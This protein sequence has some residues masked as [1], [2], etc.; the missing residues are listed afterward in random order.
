MRTTLLS[1]FLVALTVSAHASS[2]WSR[3]YNEDKPVASERDYILRIFD[4]YTQIQQKF[5]RERFSAQSRDLVED[6]TTAIL[7]PACVSCSKLLRR[8]HDT[9]LLLA[10]FRLLQHT[11]HSA[12]ESFGGHLAD[13]FAA[14]PDLVESVYRRLSPEQQRIG[15]SELSWGFGNLTYGQKRTRTIKRLEQRLT[16]MTSKAK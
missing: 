4:F 11:Q 2:E 7:L 12:S 13:I 9:G 14:N 6:Y 10:Y 16:R 3:K 8:G 5:K 1:I 15:F